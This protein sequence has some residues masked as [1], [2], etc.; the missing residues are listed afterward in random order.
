MP[1]LPLVLLLLA[2]AS[3]PAVAAAPEIEAESL[4]RNGGPRVRPNDVRVAS[5]LRAGLERSPTLRALVDRIEESHVIVYLEMQ[6]RLK[7]RLS[8]CV[9]WVTAVGKYRYV[10]TSINPEQSLDAQIAALAHE[11]H[12]VVEIIDNPQVRS[13]SALVA[14]YRRIGVQRP[15]EIR[16]WDTTEAQSVTQAVRRELSRPAPSDA[17]AVPFE[18]PLAWHAYYRQDKLKGPG[19]EI[20]NRN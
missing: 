8:G 5:L 6:P 14:L 17:E 9:S 3:V 4:W 15:A 16:E 19:G 18:T 2:A 7:A 10:R 1:T 20:R 11:L 13:E 12:H